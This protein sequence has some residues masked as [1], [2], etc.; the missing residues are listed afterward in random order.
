MSISVSVFRTRF[1]EFSDVIAYPDARIQLFIDDT[2]ALYIG[3][4]ETRW[5]GTYN[6]A[7]AYLVAHM[8]TRGTKSKDGDSSISSGPI[9]SK[10]VGQVS[11]T[12]A[13]IS[14]PKNS[15][16]EYYLST[17]YGQEFLNIRN[18]NFVGVIAASSFI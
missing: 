11:V 9:I 7:Q 18:Q 1:P 4:N 5:N 15:F 8:L 6:I 10:T 13:N 16:D 12:R 17:T 2:V 14:T 3:S